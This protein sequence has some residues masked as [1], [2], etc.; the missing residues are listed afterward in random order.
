MTARVITLK[1]PTAGA[2]YV[3]ALPN[4]YLESGEPKGRWLGLGA[5][6]LELAGEVDDQDFLAIMAG[7]DP[8]RP[9][10]QLGRR[11]GDTS[12]RGFDITCSAPKSVSV[13]FA[14]GDEDVRRQ[15]TDAHDSAVDAV[16]GWIERTALT[17]H[18]INGDVAVV[19]TKGIIAAAFRQHTSRALDPQIHT[20]LVVA[21]RV[22]A[23]D[24]RWLALDA[25]GLKLDQRTASAIY[26]V[27]LHAELTR[28]LG[29]EWGAT[30]HTIAEIDGVPGELVTAFS[31]RT[32]AVRRRIDTKIDRFEDTMG[33]AP[34]P[35]ERWKLER[36]AVLDSRPSKEAAVSGHLLHS[37]WNS[38]ASALGYR[39]DQVI[40]NAVE[41][42]YG[43]GLD[44]AV[45]ADV[46]TDAVAQLEATQSTWR[47]AELT[48]EIARLLPTNLTHSPDDLL[49]LLEKLT[50][51]AVAA[52]CIDLSAPVM[53]N[54]QLRRDGRPI[55]ESAIDRVLTTETILRQEGDLLDW[56]QQRLEA[57]G[58]RSVHATEH[59]NHPLS[60]PQAETAAAVAG[61]EQ[62][63]LVVGPAGTGKTTA[64]A[65]AVEQL[66]QD[67][68]AV[69]GVAPSAAA[70]QVLATE[71]GVAADTVDKLL[72]EHDGRRP[73]AP[74]YDLPAGATVIV[75]EAGMVATDTLAR[76][77]AL[78]DQR[79]WRIA[80]VGD[81]FQFSAVGRGGM[82][83]H[84]ID[85]HGAIELDRVHRF[86][87]SWERDAS[88][89]LR[90]G[91]TSVVDL[92]E[93]HGRIHE[94]TS[95]RVDRDALAAWVQARQRGE[96]VLLSAPTN[97]TADRL[98]TLAQGTRIQQGELD[99]SRPRTEANGH[100]IHIGDEV[101]T[102]RN[103]RNLT[104]DRGEIVR[105]RDTWVVRHVH[106]DGDVTA[107]GRS[108]TVRLPA[109]YV[110]EHLQL[111]YAQT[112]HASQ[113]RTVDRSILVLDGPTDLPGIYVPLTRGRLS[114]D[115]YVAVSDNETAIDVV[116]SSMER[117]WIDRPAHS[118]LGPALLDRAGLRRL[119]AD[120]ESLTST[121]DREASQL[122]HL[123]AELRNARR[124]LGWKDESIAGRQSILSQWEDRLDQLGPIRRHLN[125]STTNNVVG[126]VEYQQHLLDGLKSDR[127]AIV[128]RIDE[129]SREVEHHR[130]LAAGHP[131]LRSDARD[132]AKRLDDD[133]VRR[134]SLLPTKEGTPLKIDRPSHLEAA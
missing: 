118:H 110:A 103:E 65:P 45:A 108:G 113:G 25:R 29:V 14:L 116:V 49:D 31:T 78:A 53:P 99:P 42:E 41:R 36:E 77:A 3:E 38:R 89:R 59:A 58:I 81:P 47:P 67:G 9:G 68:R 100:T 111:G 129:L 91:D 97:E 23:P 2:Y 46:I 125:R 75:D 121:I 127:A 133:A 124:E 50:A 13:L 33:R 95:T 120:Y 119:F 122:R 109:D 98:N 48:R 87:N 128:G 134:G 27:S 76:L 102:R 18:R 7:E 62:L 8:R 1:S 115:V 20:H 82:F 21:N 131:Q 56:A 126:N 55:T 106:Q 10:A 5:E 30:E 104:T 83:N 132:I 40:A 70:A 57:G 90:R 93:Q 34:T 96:S 74:L 12:V 105:N 71:C 6:K 123:E 88:L 28:R 130:Q 114:N 73:P 26:H 16:A 15:V 35:R 37:E 61:T 107:T 79:Q 24:G 60:G 43:Y 69:F 63:V 84:L 64:L 17:R 86:A 44:P 32:E 80:L 11:F 72:V 85:T 39:A 94:G 22:V 4:Y 117:H 51:E 101:V 54:A 112:S 66:H 92:Y 19:D 52:R